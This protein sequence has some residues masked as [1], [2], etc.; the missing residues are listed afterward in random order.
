[1]KTSIKLL[2]LGA[3]VIALAFGINAASAKDE[4]VI[5][6]AISPIHP[7]FAMLDANG[8]NVLESGQAASTM[9]TCGQCHDTQFIVSHSY[10][11]DLGLSEYSVRADSWDASEGYFGE[12]DPINYRFLSVS[13]DERMDLTTAD[14]LITFGWRVPGGGPAVTARDGQPLLSLGPDATNPEA[15]VYDSATGMYVGWDWSQ[16]GVIEMNCFLCHMAEPNNEMRVQAIERGQFGWANTATLVGTG[17]VERSSLGVNGFGWNAAAFDANGELKEE[18]VQLRDPT[19]ENCAA[20]HGEIHED[21]I[22]PLTLNACDPLQTQTATTGQVIASQKISESGL[23]LDDKASLNFA[24][25]IHAERALKCTDC[26][27]SLNNPAHALDEKAANP[28]HLVYDPRKLEIGEY[29]QMPDHNFARGVSAQFRLAPELKSTM[30]RCDSC[31]DTNKSHAGWLPYNDRHMQVVAC[32][33]CHIPQMHAPAIASVDWTVVR[34]DGS[35]RTE[36]RGIEGENTTT[37]L[38]TGYQ[39]VLMQRTDIEDGRTLLAPYNLITT[40]FWVYEDANG[41]VRPVRK[42]DLEAAYLAEDGAYAPDVLAAFDANNDGILSDSELVLNDDA[43][44]TLI[45]GKLAALGLANVRIHGQVQPYSINHNVVDGDSATRDCATCHHTDSRVTAPILLSESAPT[46]VELEFLP[47]VNVSASGSVVQDGNSLYYNPANEN[48]KTYVFGHNRIAWIDWLG[49]LLFLGTVVGIGGHGTLRYIAARKRPQPAVQTKPVYMYEVY[50]RFWHWLQTVAIVILLLTGLVIHR[51]DL[52][53]SFSFRH[54]V[55]IHNV[56][57][58][59]LGI[60]AVISIFWHIISGEIQQYIPHPYGFIDQMVAQAKY[61]IQGIFRH[62][63]HPFLKSKERKF[64]PL[65][66]ITYVGLL[67]VLLPLQGLSGI[68]MWLVQKVPAIQGW[69]G[70][71]TFLAPFHTMSAW[72]FAAFVVAHVYLTTTAG[73]EP[74]DAIQAMITGWE[75]M[76]VHENGK[77]ATPKEEK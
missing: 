1:M 33:T 4:A 25:D 23:N 28:S 52:F 75:D 18:Y 49:A 65:Q 51:P 5:E 15:S 39:P 8:T 29:L 32:E 61:Y 2:L 40:Y 66:M 70:G 64:N 76:E 60:N 31:H 20:C 71:L 30:R 55:T 74:L 58:A 68:M 54:I 72:L 73:H 59:L 57:A 17:I 27:Y 43:K 34:A 3:L 12:F 48:D 47:G 9:Q 13:G 42:A 46:G 19:N 35:A 67:G 69:F 53:G 7:T 44:Q 63:P 41:N 24:W 36:C 21:P 77:N 22:A 37:D 16:S 45:A 11:A 6:T 14:W 56:L 62:E 10:H 50:E 38:V 26:H